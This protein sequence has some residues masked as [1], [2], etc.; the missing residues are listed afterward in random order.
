MMV[1]IEKWLD[2]DEYKELEERG[3]IFSPKDEALDVVKKDV[4]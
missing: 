1:L 4:V 2:D 3:E